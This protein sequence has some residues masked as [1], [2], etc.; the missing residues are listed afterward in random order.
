M[1]GGEDFL[2]FFKRAAW[3]KCKCTILLTNISV[4]RC[5]NYCTGLN[6]AVSGV[7]AKNCKCGHAPMPDERRRQESDCDDPC[8][9]D[10]SLMCGNTGWKKL[11]VYHDGTLTTTTTTTTTT[12]TTTN[13]IGMKCVTVGLMMMPFP[14]LKMPFSAMALKCP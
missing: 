1:V 6:Y 13:M 12:A 4:N 14:Y 2:T 5:S 3:A 10:S 9:G 8:P 7:V 11:S